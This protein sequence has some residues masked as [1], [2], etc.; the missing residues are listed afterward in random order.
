[1]IA[2]SGSFLFHS[3]ILIHSFPFSFRKK[4]RK[5]C[6]IFLRKKGTTRALQKKNSPMV[7]Y[8]VFNIRPAN[9]NSAIYSNYI[10]SRFL[11]RAPLFAEWIHQKKTADKP[12]ELFLD[13]ANGIVN[14]IEYHLQY[15]Q[16][17][18]FNLQCMAVFYKGFYDAFS[19]RVYG[20]G[21]KR[22]F[23]ELFLYAQ[24]IIYANYIAAL[25]IAYNQSRNPVDLQRPV[26]LDLSGKLS[27]LHE[28]GVI[29]FLKSKYAGLDSNSF[30]NKVAEM[31][32]LIMGEHTD[33][34]GPVIQMLS[35]LSRPGFNGAGKSNAYAIHQKLLRLS[36]GK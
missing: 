7:K 14:Q 30:E 26:S 13:E 34:K 36:M 5:N 1:M 9:S 2:F 10:L 33:Q 6:L 3:L 16:D 35:S 19:N 21:K 24:G 22:K 11:S 29:D 28:L 18:R 32:C 15:E 31:L 17:K 12:V 20:S 25:K 4:K 8:F 23:I 27:L